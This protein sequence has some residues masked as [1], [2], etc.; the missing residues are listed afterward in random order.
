MTIGTFYLGQYGPNSQLVLATSDF[1]V[2]TVHGG[3]E[4]GS[5]E[6]GIELPS[7][8]GAFEIVVEG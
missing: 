2:S 6:G 1:Q 7:V 5:V 8:H 3:F 4:Q